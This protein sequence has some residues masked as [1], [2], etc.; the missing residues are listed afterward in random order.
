MGM[1]LVSCCTYVCLGWKIWRRKK[2]LII[3]P[4]THIFV[5]CRSDAPQPQPQ[6]HLTHHNSADKSLMDHLSGFIFLA[7]M[8]PPGPA[9]LVLPMY[10]TGTALVLA[11]VMA[12]STFMFVMPISIYARKPHVR[13]TLARETKDFF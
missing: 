13:A 10:L 2:K 4:P 5:I 9:L 7:L 1:G 11:R 3:A 12:V 6:P 8:L